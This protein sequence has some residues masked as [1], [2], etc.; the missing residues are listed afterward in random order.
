MN[1]KY[2]PKIII[3][4]FDDIKNPYYGG[5]GSIAIYEVFKRLTKYYAITIITGSY[6][7]SKD[8]IVDGLYYKRIGLDV[9]GPKIGQ[10][11]FQVLLPFYAL[12]KKYDLWVESFTPPF[13]TAFLP[14][15]TKKP[16]IALVHMLSAKDMQRKYKLPFGIIENIGLKF[17]K[18]FIVLTEATRDNILNINKSAQIDIIPAGINL[19]ENPQR[20]DDKKHILFLGRIEIN[21]KGID[22]LLQAYKKIAKKTGYKL[23]IAGNGEKKEVERL[24]KLIKYLGINESV[25]LLGRVDENVKIEIFNKAVLIVLPSRFENF[26]LVALEALAFKIP[27][28]CFDIEG[29]RWLPKNLCLKV[30]PF[31]VNGLSYAILKLINNRNAIRGYKKNSGIFTRGYSWEKISLLYKKAIDKSFFTEFYYA[32]LKNNAI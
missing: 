22:L 26:S 10:L 29:L 12:I 23:V 11:F 32:A 13:S 30:R 21:Q 18:R 3:S 16:V 5:G 28:I 25:E 24:Q 4:S 6:P 31:S 15:F 1:M 14:I 27:I 20:C 8:E 17:Y 2:R 7:N 19:Q 9:L